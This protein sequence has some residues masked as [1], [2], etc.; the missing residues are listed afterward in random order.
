MPRMIRNT[1]LDLET[2]NPDPFKQFLSWYNDAVQ[3]GI[4]LPDAM[5]LA[6][7]TPQGRPSARMVLY[8]GMNDK[9]LRFYTN[10]QSKKG[11]E[12]SQN[13]F[14][15]LV[16]YWS[17]LDRQIRVEGRVE[18]VSEGDSDE[19]WVSRPRESQIGGWASEQSTVVSNRD[20]L[21]KKF[22]ELNLK[23]E[24]K[25]IPRPP[26]WGGFC[27]IPDRFEFWMAGPHRLHDRFSY[28]KKGQ[29]WE[30]SRLAP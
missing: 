13:A 10:Y 19:Y 2:L 4:K 30:I 6:T 23:Y 1:H 20:V 7:V 18:K 9:G 28:E 11:W 3:A 14:A 15:A 22:Q 25:N 24:G 16:F 27:L 5:T 21:E 17:Q 29:K 8:K 12:L 26:H